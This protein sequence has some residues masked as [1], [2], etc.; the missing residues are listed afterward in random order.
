M[1]IKSSLTAL[2]ASLLAIT[3]NPGDALAVS[4]TNLSIADWDGDDIAGGFAFDGGIS[5]PSIYTHFFDSTSSVTSTYAT[6]TTSGSGIMTNGV[7]QTEATTEANDNSFTAGF[8]FNGYAFLPGTLAVSGPSGSVIPDGGGILAG[9]VKSGDSTLDFSSQGTEFNWSM[10]QGDALFM[11]PEYGMSTNILTQGGNC[12]AAVGSHQAC[13]VLRWETFPGG[14][15][16]INAMWQIEGIATF[17]G[18]IDLN[19]VPV[20]SAIWLFVSGLV[21]LTGL[22]RCRCKT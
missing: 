16:T 6:Y 8:L 17:D 9:E 18:D 7:E 3:T 4:V 2:A 10:G 21:G 5:N 20:P 22:A 13:Y 1:K 11:S 12:T 15:F 19:P 14:G